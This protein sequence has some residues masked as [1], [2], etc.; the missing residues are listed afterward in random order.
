MTGRSIRC[1]GSDQAIDARRAVAPMTLGGKDDEFIVAR[2]KGTHRFVGTC[3]Q[4]VKTAAS[5]ITDGGPGRL[6]ANTLPGQPWIVSESWGDSI[7]QKER[8]SLR[9]ALT[10]I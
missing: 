6:P 7:E 3:Q 5:V 4:V 10:D 1:V 8:R 2:D 9:A